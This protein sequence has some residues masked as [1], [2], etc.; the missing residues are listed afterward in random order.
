VSEA[1]ARIEELEADK[2]M[3]SETV[4]KEALRATEQDG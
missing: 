3:S 4:T 1:R 2:H